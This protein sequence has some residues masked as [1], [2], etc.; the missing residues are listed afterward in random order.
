MRFVLVMRRRLRCRERRTRQVL[1][2]QGEDVAEG[3]DLPDVGSLLPRQPVYEPLVYEPFGNPLDDLAQ[4]GVR[5]FRWPW[6]RSLGGAD[7]RVQTRFLSVFFLHAAVGYS[8][9]RPQ[10]QRFLDAGKLR[11]NS[12]LTLFTPPA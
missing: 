5:C 1:V 10:G 2:E 3:R 12:G 7:E 11:G 6:E 8:R 9:D 4:R